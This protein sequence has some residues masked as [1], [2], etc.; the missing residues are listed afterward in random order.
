MRSKIHV[1][2]LFV[3]LLLVTLYF[4]PQIAPA[5]ILAVT[6]HELGHVIAA[7]LCGISPDQF[8]LGFL[9]AT[10]VVQRSLYSYMKECI[11][12]I[13]GPLANFLSALIIYPFCDTS[14]LCRSFWLYSLSLGILNLL[15]I[16]SFDGGRIFSSLLLCKLSPKTVESILNFTS[17]ILIFTLWSV[18]IYL[19]LKISSS[20]SLF[21]FSVAVFAKIFLPDS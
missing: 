21:V 9:G 7:R 18:S 20:V 2:V 14:L 3:F 11:M 10:I 6:V 12:C 17:F 4:S 19:L 5:I 8:K 1:S 15:P 13:G 16:K